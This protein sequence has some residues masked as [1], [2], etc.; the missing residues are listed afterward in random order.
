MKK[1]K[2]VLIHI[3]DILDYYILHGLLES[4]IINW[5]WNYNWFNKLL[6]Y[7]M[8]LCSKICLSEWW[9]NHSCNCFYCKSMQYDD[10]KDEDE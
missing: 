9:G 10:I 5:F 1:L 7:H 8:K 3:A 2:L 6:D 4:R